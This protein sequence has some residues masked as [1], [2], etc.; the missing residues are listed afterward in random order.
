MIDRP[1]PWWEL[2]KP[3]QR[4]NDMTKSYAFGSNCN[5]HAKRF[6]N[7]IRLSLTQL[8]TLLMDEP[9]N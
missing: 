2:D 3:A 1:Q 8:L 4:F 5:K 9:D 6:H 7:V